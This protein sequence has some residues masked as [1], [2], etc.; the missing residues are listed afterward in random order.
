[1]TVTVHYDT[2]MQ[3]LTKYAG[4]MHNP[5]SSRV[6][7]FQ[8]EYNCTITTNIVDP[9]MYNIEFPTEQDFIWFRLKI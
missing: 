4:A 9:I 2:F 1:M 5:Y 6:K 3:W 8:K 7:Q